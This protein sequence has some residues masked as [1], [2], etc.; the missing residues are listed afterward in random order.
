MS[1]RCK[2]LR[3]GCERRGIAVLAGLPAKVEEAPEMMRE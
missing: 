1:A 2:E 3:H